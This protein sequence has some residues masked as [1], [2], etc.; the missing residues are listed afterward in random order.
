MRRPCVLLILD[1][2]GIAPSGE[3]NAV[4]A[5]KTPVLNRIFKEHPSC[6]LSAAGLDVGLP[7]GQFGNSEVGHTNIGAG[8]IVYQ[9]L[10]RIDLAVQDNS[11]YSNEAL[12]NACKCE[13]LHLIGLVS[14]GGVHSSMRHIHALIN[15]AK[16][17]GCKTYLHAFTDGRDT[18][19]M[20]GLAYMEE[21]VSKVE[22]ASVIGRYYAMDRDSRFDRTKRAYDA[23][24]AHISGDEVIKDPLEYIKTCYDSEITDEFIPPERFAENGEIREGD[25]VIFFNFRP[26]R[27]R[28]ITRAFLEPEYSHFERKKMALTWAS[29]TQ[30]DEAFAPWLKVAFPPRGL[31]NTLG[32]WISKQGLSQLRC[33]ETEK[34]AHVTFFFNGGREQPFEGEGRILVPSPKVA[35]YDLKPEM[36]AN[37][38]ASRVVRSLSEDFYDVVVVNLANPDM[39]GHTGD[40]SAVIKA[41][42]AVDSATSAILTAT[43]KAG[44]FAVVT[45]DHGNAEEMLLKDGSPK[46]AHSAN[47]VPLAVI[48]VNDIELKDGRLC[49]VA[50]TMLGLMGVEKPCEMDG[51]SLVI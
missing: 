33:A 14:D 40:I 25:G 45:S 19:P 24:T 22:V 23:M 39:V 15:M 17:H 4:T 36:S 31:E 16:R 43:L 10:T 50:P 9:D 7:E 42:E 47:P 48:G 26:D 35:T 18:P 29:M 1:G 13:R 6:K 49:D 5:A 51:E 30:H 20:S 12:L 41:L 44:G 46:T 2:Y 32:E 27:A 11:F 34:Y 8:R 21:L 3:G 28:Q 37:E 38:V